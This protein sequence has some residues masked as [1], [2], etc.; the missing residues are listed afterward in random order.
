MTVSEK[1]YYD[2]PIPPRNSGTGILVNTGDPDD[3]DNTAMELVRE[4]WQ[5]NQKT[6]TSLAQI[7]AGSSCTTLYAFQRLSNYFPAR[8]IVSSA[9]ITDA[10]LT[11]L[12]EFVMTSSTQ[13]FCYMYAYTAS[14]YP[15]WCAYLNGTL[16]AWTDFA[17]AGSGSTNYND[18]TNK[19][20]IN[21]VTLQGNKTSANLGLAD[22]THSHAATDITSGTLAI[23]NGGTG[24]TT[25]N[26]L[27]ESLESDGTSNRAVIG[28]FTNATASDSTTDITYKGARYLTSITS[29][30][31]Y[32]SGTVGNRGFM[33]QLGAATSN[34]SVQLLWTIGSS[35][36]DMW[37]RCKYNG[38]WQAWKSVTLS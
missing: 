7:V 38:T 13:G 17:D 24:Q 34:Y 19:P 20:Q 12:L 6:F 2:N 8:L 36:Y 18:L 15:K 32:P 9:Y 1:E 11:G 27:I 30:K 3:D 29:T 23:A 37:V 28:F 31:G 33:F 25:L 22:A 14:N 10:P 5:M 26:D 16:S 35:S 4:K 21:S